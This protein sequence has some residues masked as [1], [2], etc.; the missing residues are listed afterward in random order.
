MYPPLFLGA[1][2]YEC[3]RCNSKPTVHCGT[4]LTTCKSDEL[5]TYSFVYRR[6]SPQQRC[7]VCT[8]VHVVAIGGQKMDTIDAQL[9][10]VATSVAEAVLC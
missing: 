3:D 4:C 5:T 2:G 7:A 6:S 10:L 8:P 9:K 1:M